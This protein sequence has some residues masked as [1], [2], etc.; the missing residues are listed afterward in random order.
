MYVLKLIFIFNILFLISLYICI[1]I[2][3]NN[4]NIVLFLFFILYLKKKNSYLFG[5]SFC[6]II[7]SP[8]K[9]MRDLFGWEPT[10]ML[11]LYCVAGSSC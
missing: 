9:W 4:K 3:L 7:C 5:P 8:M 11:A 1:I 2:F 6:Q 10:W